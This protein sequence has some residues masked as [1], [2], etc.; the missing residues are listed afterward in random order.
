MS[1]VY[2]LKGNQAAAVDPG[3]VV[4]LSASAG[5]GKTQVLSA[6]VLRLL[7]Q[8]DVR[9]EQILCL[10]FTKAGATE[11]ASRI[12]AVLARWVRLED[13]LLAKDLM[14]IGAD[15][16]EA[17]VKRARRLFAEVLD[18][19]GGGLRIDTI[20]AFAQYLLAA[21][22]NEAGLLPGVK[23][24]EDR[25]RDL[26][27]R[28]VLAELLLT[29]ERQNDVATLSALEVLSLRMGPQAVPGW[30][31][32]CAKAREAWEGPGGWQPPM[33]AGVLRLLGLA[34]DASTADLPELCDDDVFEVAALECCLAAY[35]E[36]K[37][38]TSA[39]TVPVIKLWLESDPEDRLAQLDDLHDLLFTKDDQIGR[40]H[41]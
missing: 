40:A 8:G 37:T 29:A 1:A 15:Y 33:Q 27:L 31:L 13:T 2:P 16:G 4:W 28:E 36:W 39:K 35:R 19:P 10:T 30:L 7:L 9:P 24:M 6:R 32:R 18:C 17:A 41:V 22:P 25:E 38:A 12:N 5:T 20:H 3:E 23:A 14:A 11:M 34:S 26:L 21:F